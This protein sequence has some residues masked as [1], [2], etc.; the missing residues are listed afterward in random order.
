[1][2]DLGK[3]RPEHVEA[4]SAGSGPLVAEIEEVNRLLCSRPDLDAAKRI[5]LPVVVVY[6]RE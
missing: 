4:L 6:D 1:M 2:V 5:L 3:V